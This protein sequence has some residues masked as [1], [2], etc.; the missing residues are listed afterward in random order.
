M[1]Y[2]TQPNAEKRL[3][4]EIDGPSATHYLAGDAYRTSG[5]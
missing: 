5:V 3:L 1:S 2:L 4:A